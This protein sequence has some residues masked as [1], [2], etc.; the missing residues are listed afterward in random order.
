MGG[1][2][3]RRTGPHVLHFRGRA[4]A[5]TTVGAPSRAAPSVSYREGEG[6]GGSSGGGGVTSRPAG[7]SPP[8]A[9]LRIPGPPPLSSASP[10]PADAA[11]VNSTFA[12]LASNHARRRRPAP[13]VKLSARHGGTDAQQQRSNRSMASA[14]ELGRGPAGRSLQSLRAWC[15][16]T[17]RDRDGGSWR[18]GARITPP[19]SLRD[20]SAS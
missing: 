8:A 17:T 13:H 19:P 18:P 7:Q 20:Y 5:S 9:R 16:R 1:C 3:P 6:C 10:A 4:Q 14:A 12:V 11:H 2:E 15:R